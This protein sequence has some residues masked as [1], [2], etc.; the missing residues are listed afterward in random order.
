M[1]RWYHYL[2]LGLLGLIT[3]LVVAHFQ[4]TPGYMDADYYF[5]G[6]VQLVNGNGFSEMIIWNYLDD[7]QGLPHASHA[8]WMPFA[9]MIAAIGMW[10]THTS[11]FASARLGFILI[12]ILVSPLTALLSY[13]I[14]KRRDFALAAGC[15]AIFSGYYV[16]FVSTTDTFSIYMVLGVAF[17]LLL[18]LGIIND[19]VKIRL[20]AS[21]GMGLIAGVA[22][23]SR[24]DGA[25]WLIMACLS[26]VMLPK[27]TNRLRFGS[28]L[29]VIMGY[30]LVMLPWFLRNFTEFG[31][32]LAPGGSRA[33]WLTQYDQT[34]SFP[35]SKLSL[36]SWVASGWGSI[37]GQR[38]DALIW[39]LQTTWAV[40]GLIILLPFILIGAWINRKD[41]RIRIGIIA[42]LLTFMMMT[43]AFPFAGSRGG[44][45][46]SGAALMP[47]WWALAP[48]G[49]ERAVLWLEIK[50]N[51]RK[52]EAFRVFL[53]GS[54]CICILMS[55]IL[56]YERVIS[57]PGWGFESRRYQ[58]I[59]DLLSLDKSPPSEAVLVGNP[60][61]YFNVTGRPSIAVPN[62]SLDTVLEVAGIFDARYLILESDG[63]PAPL[64]ELYV[65]RSVLSTIQYI[66][67]V[68]GA[69]I[70]AIP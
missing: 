25:M 36:A 11:D 18:G 61:G 12:S 43:F 17:F 27:I 44:F 45:F 40:Q 7:P 14:S 16:P 41:L 6:G 9:S 52:G 26:V 50:R 56:F 49:L 59:E 13:S 10:I 23:L 21:F 64:K 1:M 38:I 35:A 33:L 58:K 19:G 63:L 31:T 70:F 57:T 8:Y 4:S 55:F 51:W 29:M 66:G 67:E 28:T 37:I 46:H 60:P 30:L 32:A 47:L 3:T 5:G 2:A 15:F 62:K 54:I 20:I 42:W 48:I 22:H 68:D 39:N 65:N 24:A 69:R 53:I 34:F